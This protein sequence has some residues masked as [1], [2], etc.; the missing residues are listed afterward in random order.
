MTLNNDF[1]VTRTLRRGENG[2]IDNVGR[3]FIN[4]RDSADPELTGSIEG[5]SKEQFIPVDSAGGG[6][7]FALNKGGKIEVRSWNAPEKPLTIFDYHSE[8]CKDS[9]CKVASISEIN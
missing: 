8:A 9:S 6:P 4:R 2:F 3:V 5:F 7:T 1:A